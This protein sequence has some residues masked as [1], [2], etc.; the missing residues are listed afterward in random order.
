[1]F[2]TLYESYEIIFQYHM[3][4]KQMLQYTNT[5]IRNILPNAEM[6]KMFGAYTYPYVMSILH[7]FAQA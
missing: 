4:Q 7:L 6:G 2:S 5:E 3:G 1:M